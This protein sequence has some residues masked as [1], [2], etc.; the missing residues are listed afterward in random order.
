ML[1]PPLLS[2]RVACTCN[3]L[4]VLQVAPAHS[5]VHATM[6]AAVKLSGLDSRGG[7]P[8]SARIVLGY[9][10]G[11]GWVAQRCGLLLVRLPLSC[12]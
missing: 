8:T 5:S 4:A 1:C 3:P 11:A 2:G 9:K 7:P 12:I 6:N 10:G